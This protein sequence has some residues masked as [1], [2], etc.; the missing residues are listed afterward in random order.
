[1]KPLNLK[2]L[3]DNAKEEWATYVNTNPVVKIN[4]GYIPNF[5]IIP[6]YKD[7]RGY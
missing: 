4:D 3:E 5:A 2:G 1:M 6:I 7:Y